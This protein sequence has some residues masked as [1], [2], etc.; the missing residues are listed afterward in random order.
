MANK[1]ILPVP[2]TGKLEIGANYLGND[3]TSLFIEPGA[4]LVQLWT[5]DA[6]DLVAFKVQVTFP[7]QQGDTLPVPSTTPYQLQFPPGGDCNCG[8]PRI[9][10]DAKTAA[11]G[12]TTL[13]I[14]VA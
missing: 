1:R 5:D 7:D 4:R 9:Q 3:A 8:F 12:T 10:L 2:F 11:A 13:N 6:T 14:L